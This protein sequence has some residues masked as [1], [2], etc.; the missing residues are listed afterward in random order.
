VPSLRIEPDFAFQI[1][2]SLRLDFD[3]VFP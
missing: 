2:H 3:N 1:I